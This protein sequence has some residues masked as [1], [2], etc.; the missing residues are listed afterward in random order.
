MWPGLYR[1]VRHPPL[2]PAPNN[3]SDSSC[4]FNT[5]PAR[6]GIV[7]CGTVGPAIAPLLRQQGPDL[8]IFERNDAAPTGGIGLGCASSS[9]SSLLPPRWQRAGVRETASRCCSASPRSPSRSRRARSRTSTRTARSR[10]TASSSCR[11]AAR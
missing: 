9:S 11:S 6:V 1:P 5:A 8:V 4:T 3:L 7:G 2:P 10:R